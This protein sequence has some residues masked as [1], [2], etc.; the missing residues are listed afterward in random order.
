MVAFSTSGQR[1]YAFGPPGNLATPRVDADVTKP[2][3]RCIPGQSVKTRTT[4]GVDRLTQ[5]MTASRAL[6]CAGFGRRAG[7]VGISWAIVGVGLGKFA[8][9]A[10]CSRQPPG[11]MRSTGY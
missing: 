4:P 8:I 1:K 2:K 3:S 5:E 9:V 10:L 6:A 7:Q 11:T